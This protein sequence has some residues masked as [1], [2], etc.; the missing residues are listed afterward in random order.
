[1]VASTESGSPVDG[2]PRFSIVVPCYRVR[3]WL[4]PCLDSVLAQSAGDFEIIAVDDASPDDSGRIL[5]EYAA[6]DPR[7]RVVRRTEN[8]GPGEARNA[9]L[10]ECRGEY[11]LFLDADDTMLPGSL[12]AIDGRIA[13]TG[14]PDIVMF[15]YE[16][17]FWDGK[18]LRSLRHDAFAREG[19]GVFTAAERPVFLTFLE[20]V[21]NKAYRRD[22][23]QGNGF[24][25]S[26]GYYQDA[27]WTYATMLTAERIATLDRIVVHYRQHRVR[28]RLQGAH[29]RQHFD[30]FGQ[31]DRVFEFLASSPK[32][33]KWRRF[34]FDRALD[35]VLTVLRRPERLEPDDRAEFFHTAAQAANRWKP[36]GYTP[37]L[38]RRGFQRRLVVRDDYATYSTIHLGRKAARSMPSGREAASRLLHR[39]HVRSSEID[40][41]LAIYNAYWCKQYACNPRAIYERAAEIAPHVRGVWVVDADHVAAIPEGVEYVLAESPAYHQLA[42]RAKYFIAN[43][44]WPG[45]L[46]K[47][48]GQVHI[49]TQ[50]GTPLKTM[51]TDLRHYPVAAK[52]LD[53][54]DLM[55]RVD[56]WDFNISSN[57]YSSEIWDRTYPSLFQNLETGFPRNDR[58]LTADLDTVRAVRASLGFDDSH[59][60]VLYAPTFRDGQDAVRTKDGVVDLGGIG[61]HLDLD[62][63]AAAV[64]D[65]GRVLVRT[66]YS[67]NKPV[68]R[69]ESSRVVDASNHPRVEDLMLAADVLITDYSS[70]QFDYASLDRPIILLT[71]DKSVYDSNRGTYFDITEF[72]PGLVARSPQ[73]VAT[74]LS[75]GAFAEAE[76]CKRRQLFREKFCEFDDGRAAERVVRRVYLGSDD[77]PPITP[78]PDRTPA[79][80]PYWSNR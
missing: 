79:P 4:R 13:E 63:L 51:G 52:D 73:E 57:R 10:A 58:L 59:L 7:V 56:R 1:M 25:F 22:F 69:P 14:E 66:H 16:R 44:N 53:L 20:V 47:R 60:V 80:S 5:D 40:P 8:G 34:A 78:I 35:H 77:L 75:T 55:R 15:D 61:I 45:D 71:D 9:G 6:A 19:Y 68:P 29:S 38:T 3:A 74:L 11:V 27:P 17:V 37:D 24:T 41:N 31:Y 50:H 33:A 67:L 21:W 28:G 46:V 64:G 32:L 72:P 48:E 43:V 76:S 42:Q 12:E 26:S 23:L 2:V 18:M 62:A 49:Q 65:H 36:E 30:I 39:P 70:I 54:E